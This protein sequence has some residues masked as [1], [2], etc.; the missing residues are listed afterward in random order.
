MWKP[1]N[2]MNGNAFLWII[3]LG[4]FYALFYTIFTLFAIHGQ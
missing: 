1:G 4:T 2:K 3:A